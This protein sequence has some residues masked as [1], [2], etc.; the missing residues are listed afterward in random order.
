MGDFLSAGWILAGIPYYDHTY[1]KSFYDNRT[2][3][4]PHELGNKVGPGSLLGVLWY[5]NNYEIDVELAIVKPTK[6]ELPIEQCI[7]SGI[8]TR[9]QND[10]FNSYGGGNRIKEWSI[11]MFYKV[12]SD[13]WQRDTEKTYDDI[14]VKRHSVYRTVDGPM[15]R[16]TLI[17]DFDGRVKSLDVATE[18]PM[19]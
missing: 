13:D 17:T 15:Q 12:F 3:Y 6:E 10:I 2:Y 1:E 19:Q 14:K 16:G 5:D 9:N 11:D 7:A 8:K 18:I 4:S